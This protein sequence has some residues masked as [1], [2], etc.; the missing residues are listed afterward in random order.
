MLLKDKIFPNPTWAT[1]K[2]D[3]TITRLLVKGIVYPLIDFANSEIENN[4]LGTTAINYVIETKLLPLLEDLLKKK[5]VKDFKTFC[6]E[7]RKPLEEQLKKLQKN[8]ATLAEQ[9]KA[10]NNIAEYRPPHRVAEEEYIK[11][12]ADEIKK[13]NLKVKTDSKF[14][15]TLKEKREIELKQ[16]KIQLFDAIIIANS[17]K[18]N[19]ILAQLKPS[20][21][22]EEQQI[23]DDAY[24]LARIMQPDDPPKSLEKLISSQIHPKELD[25]LAT[26]PHIYKFNREMKNYARDTKEINNFKFYL[27]AIEKHPGLL[28]HLNQSAISQAAFNTLFHPD[29]I[30][31]EGE[32]KFAQVERYLLLEIK[33]LIRSEYSSSVTPQLLETLCA[34]FYR[35]HK[36]ELTTYGEYLR[37]EKQQTLDTQS[38]A[39][40]AEHVRKEVEDLL[41]KKKVQN[42]IRTQ[43]TQLIEDEKRLKQEQ[44]EKADIETKKTQLI[45]TVFKVAEACLGIKNLTEKGQIIITSELNSLIDE[46]DTKKQSYLD[47][48]QIVNQITKIV[49]PDLQ[50]VFGNIFEVS[51]NNLETTQIKQLIAELTQEQQNKLV[52]LLIKK[53]NKSLLKELLYPDPNNNNQIAVYFDPAQAL[54]AALVVGD[55]ETV[56]LL[57][58]Q[59]NL[60]TLR[61]DCLVT[62]DG[63][64]NILAL[65]FKNTEEANPE[66]VAQLIKK[67]N[68]FGGIALLSDIRAGQFTGDYL[69][70]DIKNAELLRNIYP[71]LKELRHSNTTSAEIDSSAFV[72]NA[73]NAFGSISDK[74]DI[75]KNEFNQILIDFCKKFSDLNTYNL[76]LQFYLSDFLPHLDFS[77]KNLTAEQ[78]VKLLQSTLTQ[79]YQEYQ[80]VD[81]TFFPN[82][83]PIAG[84]NYLF[85]LKG[86]IAQQLKE[87]NYP[88]EK[89]P[90]AVNQIL[91]T[92]GK[93]N[94]HTRENFA[95][96][97]RHKL[98]NKY[99]SFEDTFKEYITILETQVKTFNYETNFLNKAPA[100]INAV[101]SGDEESVR[102][103]LE[104]K[105]LNF[106]VT[107]KDDLEILVNAYK[108]TNALKQDSKFISIFN[109]LRNFLTNKK[110]TV[111]D[112]IPDNE[113]ETVCKKLNAEQ[114]QIFLSRLFETNQAKLA[115]AL[116]NAN[117]S[118]SFDPTQKNEKG[119]TPFYYALC[120]HSSAEEVDFLLKKYPNIPLTNDLGDNLL[121]Q[122]LRYY[123]TVIM[124]DKAVQKVNETV[125]LPIVETQIESLNKN[126]VKLTEVIKERKKTQ[127]LF[128]SKQQEQELSQLET[129]LKKTQNEKSKLEQ[130]KQ[131]LENIPKVG[132]HHVRLIE[133]LVKTYPNFL[134]Q[135]NPS[136]KRPADLLPKNTQGFE[137]ITA[138]VPPP[139]QEAIKPEK[140][141][142]KQQTPEAA[143]ITSVSKSSSLKEEQQKATLEQEKEWQFKIW[144]EKYNP[145]SET[146]DRSSYKNALFDKI[147]AIRQARDAE[148]KRLFSDLL[149]SIPDK[150]AAT[151]DVVKEKLKVATSA[152]TTSMSNLAGQFKWAKKAAP[153]QTNESE[154]IAELDQEL[155]QAVKSVL[156]KIKDNGSSFTFNDAQAIKNEIKNDSRL[157]DYFEP[158]DQLHI[159]VAQKNKLFK[160]LQ[161][162]IEFAEKELL[163]PDATFPL[164]YISA[165]I[166]SKEKSEFYFALPENTENVDIKRKAQ[167]VTLSSDDVLSRVTNQRA[168]AIDK[169]NIND[170]TPY[171][172]KWVKEIIRVNCAELVNKSL[173]EVTTTLPANKFVMAPIHCIVQAPKVN[174][175]NFNIIVIDMIS[176]LEIPRVYTT[177]DDTF[178]RNQINDFLK[179]QGYPHVDWYHLDINFKDSQ[180]PNTGVYAAQNATDIIKAIY[181]KLSPE[182]KSENRFIV[183]P[184]IINKTDNEQQVLEKLV[185]F[186]YQITRERCRYAGNLIT[187]IKALSQ[188]IK[189]WE[190][191]KKLSDRTREKILGSFD[192]SSKSHKYQVP[193]K[194]NVP[195]EK[196]AEVLDHLR[197]SIDILARNE[198]DAFYKSVENKLNIAWNEYKEGLTL[199]KLCTKKLETK[200]PILAKKFPDLGNIRSLLFTDDVDS[201][202]IEAFKNIQT[203]RHAYSEEK[204]NL[205]NKI[206]NT[207]YLKTLE[208]KAPDQ[209]DQPIEDIT[210]AITKDD[211][212]AINKLK[213]DAEQLDAKF[214]NFGKAHVELRFKN[215]LTGSQIK[216]NPKDE[217][218]RLLAIIGAD[219]LPD[220]L[221][222]AFEQYQEAFQQNKDI[223]LNDYYL[224]K[225][226][227]LLQTHWAQLY[228]T[229]INYH[230]Q[231]SKTLIPNYEQIQ[232]QGVT[233]LSFNESLF[234]NEYR[235]EQLIKPIDDVITLL[236][237]CADRNF[238]AQARTEFFTFIVNNGYSTNDVI[239]APHADFVSIQVLA[240]YDRGYLF[241][242]KLSG[243]TYDSDQNKKDYFLNNVLTKQLGYQEQDE[244]ELVSGLLSII[245]TQGF[246]QYMLAE[247][248]SLWHIYIGETG[249]LSFRNNNDCRLFITRNPDNPTKL[250]IEGVF[251][252]ATLGYEATVS[253]MAVAKISLEIN[254]TRD[255]NTKKLHVTNTKKPQLTVGLLEKIN[256]PNAL[257]F[258]T[259][260]NDETKTT[261]D[262]KQA[263]LLIIDNLFTDKHQGITAAFAKEFGIALEDHKIPDEITTLDNNA[264]IVSFLNTLRIDKAVRGLTA[265]QCAEKLLLFIEKNK[266]ALGEELTYRLMWAAISI[267]PDPQAIIDMG[268]PAPQPTITNTFTWILSN[269]QKEP[270]VWQPYF[271]EL[272]NKA[273]KQKEKA[274][275]AN[276][277]KLMYH[278]A[279]S[280]AQS[281]QAPAK[282]DIN[283]T[284]DKV[285]PFAQIY[286][287]CV[288]HSDPGSTQFDL[289][290]NKLTELLTSKV[291]ST[292]KQRIDATE[293]NNNLDI[294]IS[295]VLH[296]YEVGA[297]EHLAQKGV[298]KDYLVRY[299]LN[300]FS[301]NPDLD[302]SAYRKLLND[303]ITT[304]EAL[305][306]TEHNVQ[307]TIAEILSSYSKD[308]KIKFLSALLRS[309]SVF[310]FLFLKKEHLEKFNAT[311][312]SQLILGATGA[313]QNLA[314]FFDR[315]PQIAFGLDP[316]NK[317]E[318]LTKILAAADIKTENKEKIAFLHDSNFY[319]NFNAKNYKNLISNTAISTSLLFNLFTRVPTAISQVEPSDR[320]SLLN[321]IFAD[322]AIQVQQK[323][324][325]PFVDA[326]F[327]NGFTGAEYTQLIQNNNITVPALINLCSHASTTDITVKDRLTLLLKILSDASIDETKLQQISF[328]N[329]AF[330]N[331]FTSTE[332]ETLVKQLPAQALLNL[333]NKVPLAIEKRHAQIKLELLSKI[334][335]DN[336][337]PANQ[338]ENIA[339]VT[340][341]FS[342][343][344]LIYTI[345]LV[346]PITHE[347]CLHLNNYPE[348][349][350]I[351]NLVASWKEKEKIPLVLAHELFQLDQKLTKENV[352][353][354]KVESPTQDNLQALEGLHR[355]I[356]ELAKALNIQTEKSSTIKANID[357][358]KVRSKEAKAQLQKDF[359]Q[360]L[361]KHY[362]DVDITLPDLKDTII[363]SNDDINL[364]KLNENSIPTKP[365]ILDNSKNNFKPM[366]LWLAYQKGKLQE[367]T[368]I[369]LN[370]EQKEL[371]ALFNLSL[372]QELDPEKDIEPIFNSMAKKRKAIAEDPARKEFLKDVF[373]TR[374]ESL[375]QYKFL[376]PQEEKTRIQ[377][378]LQI[379]DTEFSPD[380]VTALK[381]YE[382]VYDEFHNS[383]LNVKVLMTARAKL[384]SVVAK[385]YDVKLKTPTFVP[386]IPDIEKQDVLFTS[387]GP[388]VS[389]TVKT[390]IN[391]IY[392]AIELE[393]NQVAQDSAQAHAKFKSF[394]ADN[395]DSKGITENLVA[396]QFLR[397]LPTGSGGVLIN[398]VR[399]PITDNPAT[400][401][402][403]F[404]KRLENL[405]F[406][407][408]QA[409]HL[410]GALI[411]IAANQGITQN[412]AR[413][414]FLT[415]LEY[416]FYL[417]NNYSIEINI[418]SG[419]SPD[420]KIVRFESYFYGTDYRNVTISTKKSYPEV[421]V[422][423]SV[424]YKIDTSKKPI[425]FKYCHDLLDLQCTAINSV[426]EDF[427]LDFSNPTWMNLV[428]TSEIQKF[429]LP[430]AFLQN[431]KGLIK[432]FFKLLN[433]PAISSN[434]IPASLTGIENNRILAWLVN[435]M[436]MDINNR[437]YTQAQVA[438]KIAKLVEKNVTAEDRTHLNDLLPLIWVAHTIKPDVQI[439]APY[440]KEFEQWFATE[441]V[442][443]PDY[444]KESLKAYLAADS[445]REATFNQLLTQEVNTNPA[446]VTAVESTLTTAGITSLKLQ[447]PTIAENDLGNFL[448]QC[449]LNWN[450]T[451]KADLEK[452]MQ[453]PIN[454]KN[455]QERVS[456]PSSRQTPSNNELF[457]NAQRVDAAIFLAC[458][459]NDDLRGNPAQK[460]LAEK[461]TAALPTEKRMM[462]I[463][464][465]AANLKTPAAK[466]LDQNQLT[467]LEADLDLLLKL[468]P[469]LQQHIPAE[470]IPLSTK[471]KIAALNYQTIKAGHSVKDYTEVIRE[472]DVLKTV[473]E[474]AP[475]RNL[476]QRLFTPAPI[477]FNTFALT[478]E[479]RAELLSII[480][481]TQYSKIHKEILTP[482]RE[483]YLPVDLLQLLKQVSDKQLQELT[484]NQGFIEY[485]RKGV[486][487][488]TTSPDILEIIKRIQNFEILLQ[489]LPNSFFGGI[490]GISFI[491][492][493]K[494]VDI[495]ALTVLYNSPGFEQGYLKN[496]PTGKKPSVADILN[497]FKDDDVK[498]KIILEHFA[499]E[500]R[501]TPSSI[502]K[503]SKLN[504]VLPFY[505]DI[506][507]KGPLTEHVSRVEFERV[508]DTAFNSSQADTDKLADF[509]GSLLKPRK[510]VSQYDVIK[511]FDFLRTKV[512]DTPVR[513]IALSTLDKHFAE[514]Q[515]AEIQTAVSSGFFEKV[516][517]TFYKDPAHKIDTKNATGILTNFFHLNS[518]LFAAAPKFLQDVDL[519][520]SAQ[521]T[522]WFTSLV[523]NPDISADVLT[524]LINSMPDT[525]NRVDTKT[526]LA[527]LAKVANSAKKLDSEKTHFIT[528]IIN[529][530]ENI[531]RS[532]A[533]AQK[534]IHYLKD[535][536]SFFSAPTD[537]EQD[538][539]EALAP[540]AKVVSV[541]DESERP[542]ADMAA[543]S[544]TTLV[545]KTTSAKPTA[546][547]DAA[548]IDAAPKKP[549]PVPP[550]K[551]AAKIVTK[552]TPDTP[553]PAKA[554]SA[555]S[556]VAPAMERPLP[557]DE[558]RNSQGELK[559]TIVEVIQPKEQ[560]VSPPSSNLR[561]SGLF[562]HHPKETT[563]DLK[564][565]E[566]QF[567]LYTPIKPG[568]KN[569]PQNT[570]EDLLKHPKLFAQSS[571]IEVLKT[572]AKQNYVTPSAVTFS[573]QYNPKHRNLDAQIS[574][575]DVANLD[576]ETKMRSIM[577]VLLQQIMG[578]NN[579][580]FSQKNLFS[581][582]T[583][584]I[585]IREIK[586]ELDLKLLTA[587]I[588]TDS[589]KIAFKDIETYLKAKID[590]NEYNKIERF[591][592]KEVQTK[593][594]N[595]EVRKSPVV[596]N[597]INLHTPSYLRTNLGIVS[598]ANKSLASHS[599]QEN[600]LKPPIRPGIK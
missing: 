195:E 568:E 54:I 1:D 376:S 197:S 138:L 111:P 476:F 109:T 480:P 397:D 435:T 15:K 364:P 394:V 261:P 204:Q 135:Q 454:L 46:F 209:L 20:K 456:A 287:T 176:N 97:Y 79:K 379:L 40:Y 291:L 350:T 259:Q 53:Q 594:Q 240:D 251:Y 48:L 518:A 250:F 75:K 160:K 260:P 575:K 255:L 86:E 378:T 49:D 471:Q 174:Q 446:Q 473:V 228:L 545:P 269:L 133:Y 419:D 142:Q 6:D 434:N 361:K 492:L 514:M 225:T 19:E 359:E 423:L 373:Q 265:Q 502:L 24:I 507:E 443:A 292:L 105:T 586:K 110:V 563:I 525:A 248:S 36:D 351:N 237:Q 83:W 416:Q 428:D 28:A 279:S 488:I 326:Q 595:P 453:N 409:Q 513:S 140:Q 70:D 497:E 308:N 128:R 23:V 106:D 32:Q 108:L 571:S 401:E 430:N 404:F 112:I 598:Q 227:K 300:S 170:T 345:E 457:T 35:E 355:Q 449:S 310:E 64:Y 412:I 183:D 371:D 410:V 303:N 512:S 263:E 570:F 31:Y 323:E 537:T 407:D 451:G 526:K 439:N 309:Q 313:T 218:P 57:N 336:N 101:L 577:D 584:Y 203:S 211:M 156:Q 551:K 235:N 564:F 415:P 461:L 124:N 331:D 544:N 224:V 34:N 288:A 398:G 283:E 115:I 315:I 317:V 305:K 338:K 550:P 521:L 52:Q 69:T 60:L 555:E 499:P 294:D 516:F 143:P 93:M 342:K 2:V 441:F 238:D 66:I 194:I 427:N 505:R 76:F 8:N 362:P 579:L 276:M 474:P 290:K 245:G 155:D 578:D 127:K 377:R 479:N 403:N 55:I 464:T 220:E 420:S 131:R 501:N 29:D 271:T 374:L 81:S 173:A 289:L 208:T 414:V 103:V 495:G 178:P 169:N 510:N 442:A 123:F 508:L 281:M 196:E 527:M 137:Q 91:L 325:I 311:E 87:K 517:N 549:L 149:E 389:K 130:E 104:N 531:D 597:L 241:N 184:V 554:E 280:V 116:L 536:N 327:F 341:E 438:E 385:A 171:D 592:Q 306:R 90:A 216:E 405:G 381:N 21:I 191:E 286:L 538:L 117:P 368:Q 534:I 402:K 367:Q 222:P 465:R 562:S 581:L 61:N 580:L 177:A 425:T 295:L 444:F 293:K 217:L 600:T 506:A 284:F 576:E 42:A 543:F 17:S 73:E 153:L 569:I 399:V 166:S 448:Y 267:H 467:Q 429:N 343:N 337:I 189:S 96:F 185:H 395:I 542:D 119:E 148:V 92:C 437:G 400:L 533:E 574:S 312:I 552:V 357:N 477:T 329:D 382:K 599:D 99:Q 98:N 277:L 567:E 440:Q 239:D 589:G 418:E 452:A 11:Y 380:L 583:S 392:K 230:N 387:Y 89:I 41:K 447:S 582:T 121:Y 366:M 67:E 383:D 388:I 85:K 298:T 596:Q 205:V 146:E 207:I 462:D 172:K 349:A 560:R 494:A 243:W 455:L 122:Y 132:A 486:E 314:N 210:A 339:F 372:T 44:A 214:I 365:N 266:H 320:L 147:S 304:K 141:D 175:N 77:S 186:F 229:A 324:Q 450:K 168:Q 572:G 431:N 74:T 134:T 296:L 559:S 354:T 522:S 487:G 236:N 78:Y 268:G 219:I 470:Q 424:A 432:E 417:S 482:S 246:T 587:E 12:L 14:I 585:F 270:E 322:P 556:R 68:Q 213:K 9:N 223:F 333:F 370:F 330:F 118:F 498:R 7:K 524:Q 396:V 484:K 50:V 546:T 38:E 201:T 139:V 63:K 344:V 352:S 136:D 503:G 558:K 167:I 4:N 463:I 193:L 511:E 426:K 162:R 540:T 212:Q 221:N 72:I 159:T 588:N 232:K 45:A 26:Y 198:G 321:K 340:P 509:F 249:P 56:H 25:N 478:P 466:R 422:K 369:Q 157:R 273:S 102:S 129:L 541:T 469:A 353:N 390:E 10:E 348:V 163:N 215:F 5:K 483:G 460:R 496:T 278:A 22:K 233:C 319:T 557:P 95:A 358:F 500:N 244:K 88:A 262:S 411:S 548:S 33:K 591:V 491:D 256:E 515:P 188:D 360:Y 307:N 302:L 493:A 58:N 519:K 565:L 253:T 299:L 539:L 316:D 272:L 154:K 152:L 192:L 489:Q 231:H 530:I 282:K 528:A 18:V 553:I 318:L 120:K 165:P 161:L 393:L 264:I 408:E 301:N 472:P 47:A 334:A 100:L 332:Y 39:K 590:K 94:I 16:L 114:Q 107:Q 65:Y 164:R 27:R 181:T 258:Y 593:F 347:S 535:D 490:T 297:L 413:N 335:T 125:K 247:V 202:S 37:K 151:T 468:E 421:S 363:T 51:N 386:A 458:V 62:P 59:Y 520:A 532:S 187:E 254:I 475:K 113:I 3:E 481:E 150:T 406:K 547:I 445:N 180:S 384:Y 529:D 190:A 523:K 274:D 433:N 242:N 561:N 566:N 13:H 200:F 504:E 391:N 145:N 182:K 285:R 328:I 199:K 485:F 257:L 436:R 158:K 71:K 234:K 573:L 144:R 346:G 126:I 356:G 459:T 275:K 206:V 252:G 179:Q 43:A 84:V 375:K 82:M 30:S 226:G 80:T